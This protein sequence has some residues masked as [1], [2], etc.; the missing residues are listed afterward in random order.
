MT[1]EHNLY[2][3]AQTA[4]FATLSWAEGT[5]KNVERILLII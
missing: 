2:K 3:F 5:I 1:F 4:L